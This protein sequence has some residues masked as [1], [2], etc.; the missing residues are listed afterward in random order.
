[1]SGFEHINTGTKS[2]AYLVVMVLVITIVAAISYYVLGA[3]SNSG[4]SI[5]SQANLVAPVTNL[6]GSIGNIIGITILIFFI[7]IMIKLLISAPSEAN[8]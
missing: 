1:M 7:V 8:L 6:F 5:P 2:V 3:L 4:I